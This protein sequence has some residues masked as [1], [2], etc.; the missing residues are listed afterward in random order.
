MYGNQHSFHHGYHPQYQQNQQQA[1]EFINL[2]QQN[3]PFD[4]HNPMN[5]FAQN[6][7]AHAVLHQ[8]MPQPML[9][10]F[11]ALPQA[12]SSSSFTSSTVQQ[13]QSFQENRHFANQ[14]SPGIMVSSQSTAKKFYQ[15]SLTN[16]S[17]ASNGLA[18]HSFPPQQPQPMPQNPP[19]LMPNQQ[20]SYMH[21]QQFTSMSATSVNGMPAGFPQNQQPS[22]NTIQDFDPLSSSNN[23]QVS[24]VN[25]NPAMKQKPSAPVTNLLTHNDGSLM[26][27]EVFLDASSANS[28][29][30]LNL[31]AIWGRIKSGNSSHY[32]NCLSLRMKATCTIADFSLH[33]APNT[34]GLD[35][36]PE[37]YQKSWLPGTHGVLK[38]NDTH[39]FNVGLTCR[40][41]NQNLENADD[42]LLVRMRFEYTNEQ[43]STHLVF[44]HSTHVPIHI[45]FVD[46]P[47]RMD[48]GDM[49]K[50]SSMALEDP[51]LLSC[52]DDGPRLTHTAFLDGWNQNSLSENSCF[53][54]DFSRSQGFAYR[55]WAK[56]FESIIQ[57]QYQNLQQ[58][59]PKLL[60]SKIIEAKLSVNRIF[61]VASR[62]VPS[63]NSHC[64]DL[65]FFVSFKVGLNPK[66]T[67]LLVLGEIRFTQAVP[68]SLDWTKCQVQ[69]KAPNQQAWV[70]KGI[71]RSIK[72]ILQS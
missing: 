52:T 2:N 46:H 29:N 48:Y 14:Q 31:Q 7:L 44:H 35:V 71:E 39:T 9:S 61:T 58:N 45:F 27:Q 17:M 22:S 57:Q 47:Q 42:G 53:E 13:Q 67:A 55:R 19:S 32:D 43:T 37:E 24:I 25:S 30:C 68:N 5:Q 38:A 4:N 16:S 12:N 21:H 63:E 64:G 20:Q 28:D 11:N 62:N 18:N 6:H 69:L 51:E 23:N 41:Q 59:D 10:S 49:R 36:E 66:N 1:N 70:W 60:I 54:I 3:T 8:Q 15:S 65:V 56:N 26:L 40:P 50:Q 72:G 33:I 34:L